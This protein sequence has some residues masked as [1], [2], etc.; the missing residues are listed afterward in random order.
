MRKLLTILALSLTGFGA[1]AG[2]A[3]ADDPG[4]I[5]FQS[6]AYGMPGYVNYGWG[7]RTPYRTGVWAQYGAWG[8]YVDGCTSPKVYCSSAR[9]CEVKQPSSI[10]MQYATGVPVTMNS[11]IR[12]FDQ[13]G[14]LAWHWDQSCSGTN[15]CRI[16]DSIQRTIPAGYSINTQCN[17]VRGVSAGNMAVDTCI[18]DIRT[19]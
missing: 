8:Y 3:A 15:S 7:C 19:I 14:R 4:A 1:A 12:V 13:Y 18:A 17:G 9:P 10:R 2:T 5:S 16:G 6:S 11:R